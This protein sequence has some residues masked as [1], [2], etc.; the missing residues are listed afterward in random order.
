M[1]RLWVPSFGYWRALVS[2]NGAIARIGVD[3]QHVESC[4]ATLENLGR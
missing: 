3:F 1:H 4:G 2:R